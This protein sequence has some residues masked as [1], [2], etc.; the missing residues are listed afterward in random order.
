MWGDA[1]EQTYAIRYGWLRGMYIWTILISGGFGLGFLFAPDM[2]QAMMG[3]PGQEPLLIGIIGSVYVAFGLVSIPG[4]LS[5]VKFAPVLLLQ[6]AYKVLWFLVIFL[7]AA[8]MGTIPGYGWMMAGLFATFVIGDL[9]A[10][11][12]PVVF[13]REPQ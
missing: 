3:Y 13:A 2:V 6:L 9:I 4:F 11:P 12:F 8:V 1:V 5:P 7:P 10:I